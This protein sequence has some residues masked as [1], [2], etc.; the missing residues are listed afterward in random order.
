MPD[1]KR[2]NVSLSEKIR[3]ELNC[4]IECF[5]FEQHVWTAWQVRRATHWAA[6]AVA[7]KG[8][9]GRLFRFSEHSGTV[10]GVCTRRTFTKHGLVRRSRVGLGRFRTSLMHHQTWLTGG[11]STEWLPVMLLGL[12]HICVCVSLTAVLITKYE[13]F[14]SFSHTQFKKRCC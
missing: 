2:Q 3:S 6:D 11:Y 8:R 1:L 14:C 10:A 5:S 13:H 7:Q 12:L 4:S 9:V